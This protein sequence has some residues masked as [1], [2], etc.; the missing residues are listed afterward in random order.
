M[1][2]AGNCLLFVVCGLLCV[3]SV[4][5]RLLCVVFVCVLFDVGWLLCVGCCVFR[6]GVCVIV[7]CRMSCAGCRMMFVVFACWRL[8]FGV[9]CL[10]FVVR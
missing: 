6:C 8:L 1:P 10:L 3:V 2:I 7:D 4:V 5:C 9:W